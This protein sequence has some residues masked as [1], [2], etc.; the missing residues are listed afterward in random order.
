MYM[1]VAKRESK[2]TSHMVPSLYV[3]Y[4]HKILKNIQNITAELLEYFMEPYAL[5]LSLLFCSLPWFPSFCS[6]CLVC[7]YF[8]FR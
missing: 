8:N 7:I 2:S 6:S 3:L 5:L 1:H 4:T